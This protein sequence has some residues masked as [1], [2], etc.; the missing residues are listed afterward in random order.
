MNFKGWL[1]TIV[2]GVTLASSGGGYAGAVD[3]DVATQEF[4]PAIAGGKLLLNVRPRYEY[5][6]QD[7]KP[8]HAKAFTVR[9]L[10]GWE[11]MPF[12]GFAA[13]VQGIDVARVGSKDYNDVQAAAGASSF[14]LVADPR[15]TDINQVFLDYT[16]LSD[17][18][19]RLGK[20]SIKIDN[21]RFIGN[22]E[23]RQVMQVFNGLTVENK[24]IPDTELYLAHLER[25]KTVFAK[26]REIRLDVLHGAY[27]IT[28]GDNLT[29]YAYFQD[30]PVT[31][32]KQTSNRIAG[33]RADG[34]HPFGARFKLLY[35]AEY[36]KQDKFAD[37]SDLIKADYR[38][39][40]IGPRWDDWFVRIDYEKLGSNGGK[41]AF[42]TPFGTNHLFQGWVDKFLTTPLQGIRDTFLSAG[43]KIAQ[44]QLYAEYHRF[45]SDFGSIDFGKEID[46]GVT[47]PF[48]KQFT[49]KLEYGAYREG[50]VL[51]PAASRVR[52]TS[53]FWVT[54]V[55]N[56]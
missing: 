37:G 1:S 6:D 19:F 40:G 54:L 5:V 30:E 32:F 18:R 7:G 41:Y 26:Q 42:Q 39:F 51:K 2:G 50:D 29:G 9:T 34:A 28:P 38:H 49:G 36:A 4:Y 25:V 27:K 3:A 47:Y 21:V 33:L 11:T 15:N 10:I 14:P 56:Y 23:F 12:H 35:T 17:T 16:G 20:Q 43:S 45:K 52:D 31:G 8:E 46:L 55:Y 22:V 53:K 13:T 44:A 24:S 48:T